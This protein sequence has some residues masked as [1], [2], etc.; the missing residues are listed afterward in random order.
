MRQVLTFLDFY[1]RNWPTSWGFSMFWSS[2]KYFYTLVWHITILYFRYLDLCEQK[3]VEKCEEVPKIVKEVIHKRVPVQIEGKVA[4]RVCPGQSDH[5][6][7]P[8]EVS[9]IDFTGY[10]WFQSSKGS[11]L[12]TSCSIFEHIF[13]IEHQNFHLMRLIKTL[14]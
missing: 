13:L 12:H 4:Y 7:T 11:I 6:Y 9:T 3:Q 5:E 2:K 14:I 10:E 8:K 1:D